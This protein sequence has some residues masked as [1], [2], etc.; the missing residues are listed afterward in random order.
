MPGIRFSPGLVAGHFLE[1]L[2]RFAALVE[3]GGAVERVHV[4]NSGRLRE[5]FRPGRPV[6]L[7]PA[8]GPGRATRFTLAL[9]RLPG[10]YV[11]A[12]AHLPN[13][14]VADALAQDGVPGLEGYRVLR[15]EPVI[16]RNRADFLLARGE[17]WCLL[18]V[19]SV[20][21]VE[22]GTALFPDAPTARGCAHLEHLVAARRAGLAA[23][24]LFV[25]QRSDAVALAPHAAA[26]P[27]FRRALCRAVRAG[28]AALAMTCRATPARVR[29]LQPVPVVLPGR[30]LGPPAPTPLPPRSGSAASRPPR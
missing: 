29:L 4:R 5:L 19:K 27:Q 8:A 2:N 11:S 15:R 3:V 26:D 16:G 17:R 30:G 6:L 24:I 21:L 25:I 10:G 18:E 23:A 13:A 22:G 14:L 7:A 1:R 20:T 12:D 9:V 28:V